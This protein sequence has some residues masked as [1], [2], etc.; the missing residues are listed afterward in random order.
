[1]PIYEYKCDN[2]SSVFDK[3]VSM[4][5]TDPIECPQCHSEQTRKLLSAFASSAGSSSGASGC[6]PAGSG[7]T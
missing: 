5:N 7:F 2:C 4:S 1:M 3:L 6:G